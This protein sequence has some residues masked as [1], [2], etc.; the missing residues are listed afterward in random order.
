MIE[1]VDVLRK[2]LVIEAEDAEDREEEREEA[3]E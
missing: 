2:A 3:E 1:V